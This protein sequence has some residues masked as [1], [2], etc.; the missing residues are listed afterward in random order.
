MT[1]S[2]TRTQVY[3]IMELLEGIWEAPE[4]AFQPIVKTQCICPNQGKPDRDGFIVT[5]PACMMHGLRSRHIQ[6]PEIDIRR[7][8]GYL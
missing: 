4:P 8:L 7:L 3:A 6:D 2:Y 1:T 5:S